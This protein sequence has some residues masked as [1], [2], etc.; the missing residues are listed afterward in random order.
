MSLRVD[1][2]EETGSSSFFTTAVQH[3]ALRQGI[4]LAA[5]LGEYDAAFGYLADAYRLLCF[6]QAFIFHATFQA[7]Y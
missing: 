6:L 5:T 7:R 1:L 3:R 4:A 2:W